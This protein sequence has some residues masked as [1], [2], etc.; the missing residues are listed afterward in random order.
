M[1]YKYIL[2]DLDGT[3]SASAAG[4]RH[5]LEK[6]CEKFGV[7]GVDFSN[8]E[9]YIG[10]PLL[11][12]LRDMCGLPPELWDDAYDAYKDVYT[13]EGRFM[14]KPY[15]GIESVLATLRKTGAK[16]AVCTSKLEATAI[17]VIEELGLSG[18]FD[19]VCGSNRDSTRKD[20][21]DLIPYAVE[22]LGGSR[23]DLSEAVMLGDTWYDAK[24][25]K[26]CGVDFIAC[27]YGY[28]NNDDMEK[29]DPVARAEST[30][31]IADILLR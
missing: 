26:E 2:F 7:S 30:E 17:A 4:I 14:N 27:R 8:Y 18:Y 25:A 3:I 12:T 15:D 20:K 23:D 9:R 24:G 19:A 22:T 1:K 16:L 13:R 11:D 28:G 10:P 5:S 29:Y 6:A 21:R 31:E